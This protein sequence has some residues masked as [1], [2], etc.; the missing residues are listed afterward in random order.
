MAVAA[1]EFFIIYDRSDFGVVETAAA[2][3][4]MS[5]YCPVMD[6]DSHP[7]TIA[8]NQ[9]AMLTGSPFDRNLQVELYLLAGYQNLRRWVPGHGATVNGP[10]KG[11]VMPE[12]SDR[13]EAAAGG[14]N[15]TANSCIRFCAWF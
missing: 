1:L 3:I 10:F 12:F 6:T 14:R 5:L 7:G 13:L 4:L 15:R 11:L 8:V 9:A 2:S